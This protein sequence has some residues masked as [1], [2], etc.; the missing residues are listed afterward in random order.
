MLNYTYVT[1]E[2]ENGITTV[3]LNN[4]PANTLSSSCIA[5][6]RSLFQELAGMMTQEPLSSQE[7]AASLRQ[8]RT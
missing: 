1:L 3:T 4:P 8:E 5:E 6:M 7:Q 2:K